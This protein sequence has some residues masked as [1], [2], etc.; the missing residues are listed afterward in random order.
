M[1]ALLQGEI[2]E[3]D[4]F[5]NA[6]DIQGKPVE[7]NGLL[8][9]PIGRNGISIV[10]SLSRFST[11]ELGRW[12]VATNLFPD[13]P[14]TPQDTTMFIRDIQARDNYLFAYDENFD[15][16]YIL[17]NNGTRAFYR[18]IVSYPADFNDRPLTRERKSH[19][20]FTYHPSN[21]ETLLFYFIDIQKTLKN[22]S[23]LGSWFNNFYMEQITHSFPPVDFD[24]IN[25]EPDNTFTPPQE[26]DRDIDPGTAYIELP[27]DQNTDFG[28]I[29][30][31]IAPTLETTFFDDIIPT[32]FKIIDD[33]T[34][35]FIAF[36]Y[37]I[38]RGGTPFTG[39]ENRLVLGSF[40]LADPLNTLTLSAAINLGDETDVSDKSVGEMILI[41]DYIYLS[42]GQNGI[43]SF[44]KNT[45]P[46]L[47]A[48]TDLL[49]ESS[50]VIPVLDLETDGTYLFA[51]TQD[52][53]QN[54]M[55]VLLPDGA[56][57]LTDQR[58]YELGERVYKGLFL[59]SKNDFIFFGK[60]FMRIDTWE[61]NFVF[62]GSFQDQDTQPFDRT[63]WYTNHMFRNFQ[64]LHA[65]NPQAKNLNNNEVLL[66][67]DGVFPAQSFSHSF[68]EDVEITPLKTDT[69][70]STRLLEL[71]SK[72]LRDFRGVLYG[73]VPTD[74]LDGNISIDAGAIAY[75]GQ[76][77]AN[78]APVLVNIPG[79]PTVP[80][81]SYIA[82]NDGTFALE[83]VAGGSPIPAG[84]LVVAR[85]DGANWTA[86]PS[87]FIT[88]Q[89]TT[90]RSGYIYLSTDGNFRLDPYDF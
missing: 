73:M 65:N 41:G 14:S 17:E 74:L 56:G 72:F 64:F 88:P 25:R 76:L 79:Y 6:T 35:A 62:T 46:T 4:N 32:N 10:R 81:G 3:I 70:S 68:A 13:T 69:Y 23:D 78:D 39:T 11:S 67:Y 34:T 52:T 59:D 85:Y 27:A 38:D 28:K 89:I 48:Q 50:A 22:F 55:H 45:F 30:K 54:L 47:V 90:N 86:E 9:F 26:K 75:D 63:G 12:G 44:D 57:N 33:G 15:I 1:F 8:F 66:S 16:S 61:P 82:Y 31:D 87:G 37:R 40:T 77:I 5:N 80:A 53:G 18:N 60:D 84:T 51:L 19:R 7:H 2:T 83:F 49:N 58:K 71:F 24:E 43:Y 21:T 29:A 42:I 20:F 36:N